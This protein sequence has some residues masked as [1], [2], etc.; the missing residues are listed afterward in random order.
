MPCLQCELPY[1]LE[2]TRPPD[3]ELVDLI[4]QALLE[5]QIDSEKAEMAYIWLMGC[6][7]LQLNPAGTNFELP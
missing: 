4:E 5:R 3:P 7:I 2:V 1:L 6:R